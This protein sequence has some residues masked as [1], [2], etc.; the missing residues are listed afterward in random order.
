MKV[1]LCGALGRMGGCVAGELCTGGIE[2]IGVDALGDG[3]CVAKRIEDVKGS[4]DAVMDFSCHSAVYGVLEFALS[5]AIPAVIGTTGHSEEEVAAI[6]AAAREIPVFFANN[7]SIGVALFC[8]MAAEVA[9]MFGYADVEIVET[10]HSAKRDVPSGTALMLAEGIRRARDGGEIVVGRRDMRKKGQIGVSSLRLG[11]EV[12]R[13]E[14]HFCTEL[15]HITL[16]HQAHSRRLYAVGAVNALRFVLGK[17][18]G[19]YSVTDML[20]TRQHF[21]SD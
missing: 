5:R 1:V 9:R 2:A 10:H 18:A 13:H 21:H 15:Q 16:V 3:N 17:P 14:V 8:N 20:P 6:R 4:A 11:Q 12:G 19:L 7:M